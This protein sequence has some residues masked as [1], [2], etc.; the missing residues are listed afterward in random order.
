MRT[1]PVLA[2]TRPGR[3][4]W[5][6][7]MALVGT[8]LIALSFVLAAARPGTRQLDTKGQDVRVLPLPVAYPLAK[9]LGIK[10]QKPPGA[11]SAP[12]KL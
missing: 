2:R 10:P 11:K 4:P 3:R 1:R 9:E 7:P 6:L 5:V 12:S 8:G